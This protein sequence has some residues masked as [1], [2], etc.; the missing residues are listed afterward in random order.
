MTSEICFEYIANIFIPHLNE[1]NIS[2]PVIVFLDGY[3]SHLSLQLSKFCR[4]NGLILVALC[5]N[6]THILQP[7]DIAVFGPLK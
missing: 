4:E 6:S 3:H 5:P 1:T 2:R 7:L